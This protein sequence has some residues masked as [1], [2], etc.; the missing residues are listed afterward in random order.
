MISRSVPQTPSAIPSTSS[1][2]GPG[3]GSGMSTTAAEPA[4]RGITVSARMPETYPRQAEPDPRHLRGSDPL[5][6][7]VQGVPSWAE[8]PRKRRMPLMPGFTIPTTSAADERAHLS[9]LRLDRALALA[10]GDE[11]LADDL[12]IDIA[13]SADAHVGL[14]VTEIATLRGEVGG[15]DQ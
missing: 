2:P 15:R 4:C 7:A 13:A 3:S 14:A 12:D 8:G 9:S 6:R 1:S 11:E 10:M 5:T